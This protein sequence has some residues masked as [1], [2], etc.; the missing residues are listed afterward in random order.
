MRRAQSLWNRAGCM[1]LGALLSFEIALAT[2]G[3]DDAPPGSLSSPGLVNEP[4]MELSTETF[5]GAGRWTK[6][7]TAPHRALFILNV[8]FAVI[9]I[10]FLVLRCF[11]MLS[12]SQS[13]NAF[14]GRRLAVGG[15]PSC[16]VSGDPDS[17]PMVAAAPPRLLY[18]LSGVAMPG[19]TQ[20]LCAVEAARSTAD[21]LFLYA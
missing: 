5:S 3:M 11:K 9:A 16:G 17:D 14:Q 4:G 21:R 13:N 8:L 19:T 6:R 7:P 18:R 15:A 1:A 10:T 12:S 2:S 20:I